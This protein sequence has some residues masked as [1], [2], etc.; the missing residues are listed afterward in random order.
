MGLFRK[1]A[2]R[3]SE[4]FVIGEENVRRFREDPGAFVSE[5]GE[6]ES[7]ANP[8]EEPRTGLLE[9]AGRVALVAGLALV[10]AHYWP[11]SDED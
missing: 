1:I 11:G 6:H 9:K 3:M 2:G 5:A 4:E 7:G 8:G 10:A